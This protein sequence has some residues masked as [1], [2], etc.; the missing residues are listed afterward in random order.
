MKRI[1]LIVL[2]MLLALLPGAAEAATG[3]ST[4]AGT[5]CAIHATH[6]A[7]GNR[8]YCWGAND[9]CQAGS[10]CSDHKIYPTPKISTGVTQVSMFQKG[11]CA[12][13]N[14][15]LK[16]WGEN[17]QGIVGRD[18]AVSTYLIT[19]FAIP[20]VSSGEVAQL[21]AGV[22]HACILTTSGA[23]KCWGANTYGQLGNNSY[24]DSWTA[25]TPIASGAVQVAAGGTST[26]AR[27]SDATLK[28]WGKWHGNSSPAGEVLVPTT[29]TGL[30]FVLDVAAGDSHFCIHQLGIARCWGNNTYGQLGNGGVVA[31]ATSVPVASPMNTS[32]SRVYAG[33]GESCGF[34]TD[35]TAYC[36]GRNLYGSIGDG[37]TTPSSP[38][39]KLTPQLISTLS[40]TTQLAVGS[41][42]VCSRSNGVY[43]CWGQNHRKQLGAYFDG[44][45]PAD[46]TP[47]PFAFYFWGG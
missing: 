23:V 22:Y 37:S 15:V 36:W 35:G 8:L 16:C 14:D 19:P 13:V 10:P 27:M 30:S 1:L 45:W 39:G 11:G 32:V 43:Y 31:S 25:V 21:D 47:T 2:T 44:T 41:E 17:Q 38:W 5:T 4:Y 3:I 40:S 42:N 34:K 28:C 12:V 7:S 20:G 33:L 29:V 26:C 18:P 9:K 6:G 46:P 24:I